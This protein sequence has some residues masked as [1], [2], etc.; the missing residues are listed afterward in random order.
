MHNDL[1]VAALDLQ[2]RLSALIRNAEM[3]GAIRAMVSG[4]GPTV[5]ALCPDREAAHIVVDELT[6]SG[7]VEGFVAHGSA[8]GATLL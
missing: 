2:P 8:S 7:D 6:R 5:A 3:A 1:E 4:S